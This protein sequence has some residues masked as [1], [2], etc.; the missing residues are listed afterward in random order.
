MEVIGDVIHFNFIWKRKNP[1]TLR[2]SR[3]MDQPTGL[4][5]KCNQGLLKNIILQP[6]TQRFYDKSV[7]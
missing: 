1:T 7:Y 3:N 5:L 4:Q 2:L 6:A